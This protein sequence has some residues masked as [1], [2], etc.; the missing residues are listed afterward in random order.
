MLGNFPLHFVAVRSSGEKSS[1]IKAAARPSL[2]GYFQKAKV[3]LTLDSLN[4]VKQNTR[5]R[6]H[7]FSKGRVVL[8]EGKPVALMSKEEHYR[9]QAL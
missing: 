9:V 4:F 5:T 8:Q 3:R 6:E 1:Y 2:Q 7:L